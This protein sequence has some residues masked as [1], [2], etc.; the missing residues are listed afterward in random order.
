MGVAE[1]QSGAVQS[2]VPVVSLNADPERSSEPPSFT[3]VIELTADA[4]HSG[5]AAGREQIDAGKPACDISHLRVSFVRPRSSGRG[6]RT[7]S[8]RLEPE[9][10]AIQACVPFDGL[11]ELREV[12]QPPRTGQGGCP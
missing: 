3:L 10:A 11:G 12:A 9:L 2:R 5:G 4:Y 7:T 1:G 8:G 6:G